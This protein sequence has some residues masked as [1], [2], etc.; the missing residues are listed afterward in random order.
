MS[1]CKGFS[2]I[3][4][5]IVLL[6]LAIAAAT[7]TLRVQGPMHSA[8]MRDVIGQ[9]GQFD[10]LTR[11]Y[12]RQHDQPVLMMVDPSANRLSRLAG[13]KCEPIGRPMELPDGFTIAR[14]VVG[15]RHVGA[16]AAA[17]QCSRRG[18]GP[19]YAILLEGPGD[20]RRWVLLTGLGGELLEPNDDSEVRDIL[21][22]TAPGPDA[23]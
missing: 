20:Q 1:R 15:S 23:D 11:T 5:T 12:A 2:L 4:I 17:I 6:I 3:E 16:A 21:A 19:S 8:R 18:F 10:R 13:C 9:I 14:L 7:V 22:A